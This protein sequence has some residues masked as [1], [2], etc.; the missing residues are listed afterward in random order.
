MDYQPSYSAVNEVIEKANIKFG[1]QYRLNEEK[2][3]K[4]EAICEIIDQMIPEFDCEAYDVDIDD[5]T[6]RLTIGIESFDLILHRGASS[7]FF[8]LINMVDAF[9]FSK[10]EDDVLRTEFYLNKMWERD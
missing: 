5:I 1:G 3:T 10:Q 8:E 6:K 9:R 7:Q 4:L 2:A